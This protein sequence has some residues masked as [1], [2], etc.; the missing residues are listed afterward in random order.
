M[1]FVRSKWPPFRLENVSLKM[2]DKG[3]AMVYSSK[4]SEFGG[5]RYEF[6]K[7]EALAKA[8]KRGLWSQKSI[9]PWEYRRKS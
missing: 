4:A 2:L 1:V 8:W 5:Q 9:K 3:Y 6:E 7:A